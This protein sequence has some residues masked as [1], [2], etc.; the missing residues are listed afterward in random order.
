MRSSYLCLQA[1]TLALHS[2]VVLKVATR[3]PHLKAAALSTR[4][5][6]LHVATTPTCQKLQVKSL[7]PR[8]PKKANLSLVLPF[9][10]ELVL[11]PLALG[12]LPLAQGQVKDK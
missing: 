4:S 10:L 7:H 12:T 3:P 6:L 11:Q 2:L 1:H 5:A 9:Q 8:P